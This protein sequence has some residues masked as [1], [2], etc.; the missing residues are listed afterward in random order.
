MA[1]QHSLSR[2]EICPESD[3]P[4]TL[5]PPLPVSDKRLGKTY[6]TDLRLRRFI[7]QNGAVFN[8]TVAARFA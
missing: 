7:T 4:A 1:A 8:A 6:G 2:C 3:L 5:W